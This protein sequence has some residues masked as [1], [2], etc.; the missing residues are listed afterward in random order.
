M[1]QIKYL[2][3]VGPSDGLRDREKRLFTAPFLG[4][5]GTAAT[6]HCNRNM[7]FCFGLITGTRRVEHCGAVGARIIVLSTGPAQRDIGYDQNESNTDR[8]GH[9]GLS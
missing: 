1:Q 4:E 3:T 8:I 5:L 2:L 9:S 7:V 6:R